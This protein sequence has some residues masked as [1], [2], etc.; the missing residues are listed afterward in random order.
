MQTLDRGE[1]P[2]HHVDEEEECA[3]VLALDLIWPQFSVGQTPPSPKYEREQ[4]QDHG[5][6]RESWRVCFGPV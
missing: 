5:S 6:T 1:Q 4:F 2:D 3:I